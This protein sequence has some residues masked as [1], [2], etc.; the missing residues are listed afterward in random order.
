MYNIWF[1]DVIRMF[2]LHI[3]ILKWKN[4]KVLQ[5]KIVIIKM[6]LFFNKNQWSNVFN[7][8]NTLLRCVY[9]VNHAQYVQYDL[10]YSYCSHFA[11]FFCYK[12]LKYLPI[13]YEKKKHYL[14]YLCQL[15]LFLIKNKTNKLFQ[16][17]YI[18]GFCVSQNDGRKTRHTTFKQ[19]N[20]SNQSA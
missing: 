1:I 14:G 7:V 2:A 18:F 11:N 16:N 17:I 9:I 13:A 3:C 6:F 4:I 15:I 8:R 12:I 10:L 5:L 19:T 20:Q